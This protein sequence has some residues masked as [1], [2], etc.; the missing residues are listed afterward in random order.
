MVHLQNEDHRYKGVI[1][2]GVF[3][4]I[5][6]PPEASVFSTGFER[7]KEGIFT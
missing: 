1:Q 5:E 3:L 4:A 7:L 2:K 6:T